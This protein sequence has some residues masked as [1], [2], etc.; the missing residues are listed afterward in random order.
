M[1][2]FKA[3]HKL[4]LFI[5]C[6]YVLLACDNNTITDTVTEARTINSELKIDSP[7]KT[8]P[9]WQPTIAQIHDIS[10]N[11]E[12]NF[13]RNKAY[14]DSTMRFIDSF[15]NYEEAEKHLTP[16]QILILRDEMTYY[17]EDHLEI[18]ALGCSWYCAAWPDTIF[19]SSELPKT[20]DYN[21]SAGNCHDFSLRT[22]WVEG[23]A[24]EGIGAFIQYNFNMVPTLRPTEIQIYNGYQ[25]NE[26]TWIENGRVKTLKLYINDTAIANLALSDTLAKQVFKIE[27]DR[28]PVIRTLKF[29]IVDVFS[30]SKYTDIA[31]SEL[32]FDGIGDH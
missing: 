18:G 8:L 5:I 3:M 25:K 7:A 9:T 17:Q 1:N 21:Y 26:K 14:F 2:I 6:S 23:K 4:I 13:K 28:I 12:R 27:A 11:A 31:I 30:G 20:K 24:D 29:E 10:F 16:R 22:A 19:S 32:I 15:E